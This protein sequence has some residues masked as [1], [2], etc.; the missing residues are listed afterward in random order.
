MGI[1]P[2]AHKIE[3]AVAEGKELAKRGLANSTQQIAILQLILEEL[4]K[5]NAL[6]ERK[7]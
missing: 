6:L 4:R 1:L 2:D 3:L 7:P 5:M